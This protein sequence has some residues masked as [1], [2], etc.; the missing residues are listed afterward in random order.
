MRSFIKYLILFSLPVLLF[1]G[2]IPAAKQKK[3]GPKKPKNIIL[4]IGDGMGLAQICAGMVASGGYLHFERFKCIGFSK[5]NSADDYIT[6][7]A[8]GATAISTGK[9]TYNGAVGLD[10]DS[11]PRKTILEYAEEHDLATGMV[12]TCPVTHA[13]PASFIAHQKSRT[14]NEA[15]ALDFMKT[16]IDVFIGW[17]RRYFETR[18]D[19]KNLVAEL[20]NKGYEVKNGNEIWSVSSG[21]LAGFTTGKDTLAIHQGRDS[22][23][24]TKASL[25]A[26]SILSQNKKGYF[27][28]IEGS[29]IDWG[30]HENN[31]KYV[32]DEMLDFNRCLGAV[33]D[34][35]EQE[36]NT[37]VIVTADHETGGLSLDEGTSYRKKHVEAK[38]STG[39][40]TGIMVPVFAY[41][42]GAEDFMG[43]YENTSLFDKMMNLF[44][45]Q[46]EE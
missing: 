5:T 25:T 2:F 24:L 4:M 18:R 31:I 26:L 43:I 45:F 19:K 16:D 28:M 21:K 39:H 46:A 13:T 3:K 34:Y 35:A 17:G 36:G 40:H 12:V 27:L 41:G 11:I 9:K 38:F 7:S 6:D 42:P 1:E 10:A 37:L 8:A 20:V 23:Y 32:M 14:M 33:L 30:G 44:G 15:I 22:S 29:Q